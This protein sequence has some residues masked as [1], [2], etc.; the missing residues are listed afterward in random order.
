MDRNRIKAS[1]NK[2]SLVQVFSSLTT[3]GS[4]IYGIM[5]SSETGKVIGSGIIALVSAFTF[6][7]NTRFKNSQYKKAHQ[8]S[9]DGIIADFQGHIEAR[10]KEMAEDQ[11]YYDTALVSWEAF[12]NSS[13]DF[14]KTKQKINKMFKSSTDQTETDEVLDLYNKYAGA[15]QKLYELVKKRCA[16]ILDFNPQKIKKYEEVI[17][18]FQT[19]K[20]SK[21][22]GKEFLKTGNM[23]QEDNARIKKIY[24][25]PGEPV[26]PEV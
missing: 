1:I 23:P 3:V 4:G 7:T 14:Q 15:S 8:A 9:I 5:H 6:I 19:I 12:K 13:Q 10:Q 22:L 21:R 11:E 2:A 18:L 26:T 20:P 24:T 17:A 16:L 25:H